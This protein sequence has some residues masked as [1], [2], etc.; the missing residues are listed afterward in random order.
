MN[1]PFKASASLKMI[2]DVSP[3]KWMQ[4]MIRIAKIVISAC[5]NLN[6]IVSLDSNLFLG[7]MHLHL[8]TQH[9]LGGGNIVD[10]TN[11]FADASNEYLN[12]YIGEANK[13]GRVE[14]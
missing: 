10:I 9:V 2:T 7:L 11:A 3:K 13:N 6:A 8:I 4:F 12:N 5:R 1:A 14:R